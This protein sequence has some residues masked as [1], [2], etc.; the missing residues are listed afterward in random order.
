MG[1]ATS[2]GVGESSSCVGLGVTSSVGVG[3]S[4]GVSTMVGVTFGVGAMVSV[5][6]GAIVSVGVGVSV[7]VASCANTIDVGAR[8]LKRSD[9]P[10]TME[11]N[12]RAIVRRLFMK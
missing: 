12:F 10:L 9:S 8:E 1:W 6:V 7:G 4:V 11:R 5:G 2:V 3:A